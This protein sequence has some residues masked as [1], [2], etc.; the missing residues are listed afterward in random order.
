[1]KDLAKFLSQSIIHERHKII[2]TT[3]RI[4]NMDIRIAFFKC[5]N[6]DGIQ[7]VDANNEFRMKLISQTYVDTKVKIPAE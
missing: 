1:M 6:C 4:C 7:R 2:L 3:I 5:S